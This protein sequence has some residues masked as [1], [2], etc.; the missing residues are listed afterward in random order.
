M[1]QEAQAQQYSAVL[2]RSC[3][4]PIPLPAIVAG[5]SQDDPGR[6][7]TL[8]CWTCYSEKPYRVTEIV[9]FEGVPKPRVARTRKRS[10]HSD[11]DGGLA[12]AAHI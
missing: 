2:C 7:F 5:S 9:A 3:R 1:I 10:E 4:Q 12:R 8:R 6:V 11:Q